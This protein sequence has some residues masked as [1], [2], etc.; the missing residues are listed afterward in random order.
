MNILVCFKTGPDLDRVVEQDWEQFSPTA[1][2]AYAG[3]ILGCFDESALEIALRLRDSLVAEG[4][5]AVCT[6]LT[7]G[8]KPPQAI[9]QSLLAAGFDHLEVVET[10]S[11]EFAPGWVA[12]QLADV[13][14]QGSYDL[15]LTGRQAGLADTGTVPFLLAEALG[16]PAIG[17][18]EAVS[19]HPQGVTILHKTDLGRQ[20]TVVALPAVVAIGNS[21]AAALRAV[22]L[23]AKLA[24][25]KRTVAIRPADP[26]PHVVPQLV[27]DPPGK[28]CTYLAAESPAHG[29][30]L[31]ADAIGKGGGSL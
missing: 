6:A 7:V 15:V 16:I 21:P 30:Q 3:R 20:E 14:R 23:R 24:A 27:Y 13:I 10:E 18:G 12:Q 22:T 28:V 1:D 26:A 4:R 2:L 17:E 9:W 19:L 31:L 29:A 5:T 11:G 8:Q 25:A